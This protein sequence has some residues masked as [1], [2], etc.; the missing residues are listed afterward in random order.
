VTAA[1]DT[2]EDR[3]LPDAGVAVLL[4]GER[5][6]TGLGADRDFWRVF[7]TARGAVRMGERVVV[8]GAALLGLSGRDVP[9]YEL[10][11]L[12]GPLFLPGRRRD[13]LWARQVVGLSLSP[14]YDA[15]GFRL[16]LHAGAGNTWD[17]RPDVS[18]SDLRG[19][20]GLSATRA[21]PLGLVS[22]AGGV[23]DEGHAALYV[24]LG[25]RSRD[26]PP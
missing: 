22:L 12:G 17:R 10:F 6:L 23:D 4:R 3:D 9:D 16:A 18:L 24:S 15:F 7:G 11:R 5:S 26:S 8:E 25:R 20:L 2:L 14:S 21:T 1:W 19:G 13:E